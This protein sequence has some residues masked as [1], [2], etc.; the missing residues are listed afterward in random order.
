MAFRD[1]SSL[2]THFQPGTNA[3]ISIDR[4]VT[5]FVAFIVCCSTGGRV[6][7]P[8]ALRSKLD[9]I[10]LNKPAICCTRGWVVEVNLPAV[11]AVTVV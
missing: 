9:L 6:E 4:M 1:F 8:P 2:T 7:Q 10:Y 3:S 11:D 5:N